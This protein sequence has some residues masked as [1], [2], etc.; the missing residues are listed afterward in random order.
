MKLTI[1]AKKLNAALTDA[2]RFADRKGNR[3]PILTCARLALFNNTLSIT[4]TDLEFSLLVHLECRGEYG[5]VTVANVKAMLAALKGVKGS[6]TLELTDNR[7]MVAGV[8]IPAESDSSYPELPLMPLERVT[9]PLADLALC[10]TRTRYAVSAEESR[11]TLNGAKLEFREDGL[12]MVATDGHRLARMDRPGAYR[13]HNTL[14]KTFIMGELA[15]LKGAAVE[16]AE[17]DSFQFWANDSRVIMA[18]KLTGNF[19][20]YERVMPK[21]HEFTATFNRAELLTACDRVI[22]MHKAKDTPACTLTINGHAEMTAKSDMGE[23]RATLDGA[24]YPEVPEFV[25][26]WDARYVADFLRSLDADVIAWGMNPSSN[27]ELP[28]VR[29]AGTMQHATDGCQ[30]VIMPMRP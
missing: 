14:V 23:F 13:R 6:V 28:Y 17:N 25:S 26:R 11:F 18:T 30:Y 22:A 19:P 8:A 7:L 16:F 1:D 4:A 10:I 9:V 2:K 27:P 15:K 21:P 24:R 20:D 3:I 12:R 5:G 29:D